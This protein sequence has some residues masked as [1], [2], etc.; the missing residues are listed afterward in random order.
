VQDHQTFMRN[1]QLAVCQIQQE[2]LYIFNLDKEMNS[3]TS[4]NV[5]LHQISNC[6]M[7]TL[8]VLF[9]VQDQYSTLAEN[10]LIK[11]VTQIKTDMKNSLVRKEE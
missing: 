3:S 1:Q 7:I 11:Q 9:Q 4:M 6:S 2:F 8:N 5:L 10:Y